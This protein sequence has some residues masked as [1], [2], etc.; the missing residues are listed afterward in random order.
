MKLFVT[1][2]TG[3]I[4]RRLLPRLSADGHQSTSLALPTEPIPACAGASIV[5]GDITD[6]ASLRGL[7]DGHDCVVHLAGAVGY[8]QTMQ[9][10]LRVNR[11]GTANVAR[12]AV[13]AGVRRFVHLSSVAVYGR[14]AGVVVRED[15]P[16]RK[17]GD[18]YGDT[19]VDAERVLVDRQARGE[20]EPTI[21]RPTVIYGPGDDKFLPKLVENL[22][23]GHARVI[24]SGR[25]T[26]DLV[27]VDDA[28][29]MIARC[30]TD[31]R[32]IGGVYNVAHPNNPS[33]SELLGIVASSIGA[34]PP[35]GRLAYP[36]AYVAAALIEAVA[37]L[38]GREP[39]LTR[40]AV[41][42]IGR[43]Y[44]YCVDRA[45]DELGFVP[46]IDLETGLRQCLAQD[47]SLRRT[48]AGAADSA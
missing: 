26:V 27:H 17:I 4:G 10:C 44:L 39:R 5:R 18:P 43:Q 35:R 14:I 20:L 48:A 41:R 34:R 40:Y 46:Q 15:A 19:K 7:L 16:L 12:E 47:A 31:P 28:V 13:R 1:G 29:E 42:V 9:R 6:P 3:F 36:L 24:G 22:R 25:N 37:A 11:D 30:V 33:W 23:S 38:R 8:G 45:R 21:L 32:A 2:A